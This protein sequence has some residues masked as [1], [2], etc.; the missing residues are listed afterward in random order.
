MEAKTQVKSMISSKNFRP[1]ITKYGEAVSMVSSS[2][3]AISLMFFD[4]FVAPLDQ[5]SCH[6]AA[7]ATR[8]GA[9]IVTWPLGE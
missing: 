6:R 5:H 1:Y 4:I 8:R 7:L 3:H 9:R 2:F